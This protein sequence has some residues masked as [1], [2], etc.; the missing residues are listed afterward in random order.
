MAPK[1][2]VSVNVGIDVGKHQLD[3]YIRERDLHFNVPND[4]DGIRHLVGRLGRYRLE[5]IV[6]EATGRREYEVVLALAEREWPVVVCQP[7]KV[8]RYAAARGVLAKTDKLDAALLVD[9]AAVMQPEVRPLAGGKLRLLRDLVARRRQL[10]TMRTMELNRLD[11]M[12]KGLLADIRRHVRHLDGQVAKLDQH[13]AALIEATEEW[14]DKRDILSSVPGVGPQ[15]VATLL[16]D[17]PELGTLTNKQIAALAGLAPFN[18]DSGT[19]RGRRRIRGGRSSVRTVLFMGMMS[20]IQCN[21]KFKAMYRAMVAAG[22]HKKVAL[23]ACMRKM[24]TVLNAM[25]RDGK[26]WTFNNA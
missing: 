11:V 15:V 21:P 1:R 10:I 25:L 20:A 4:P 16:A 12:P 26:E 13:L 18:R 8:R 3:V 24:I 2:E 7:I 6:V 9:Y 14:R 19:F 17:L 23:T 22:K 5:R